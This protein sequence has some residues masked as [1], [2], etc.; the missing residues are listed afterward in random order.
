V[1]IEVGLADAPVRDPRYHRASRVL[2]PLGASEE[3]ALAEARAALV[4]LAKAAHRVVAPLGVGLHVDHQ[5]T[6]AVATELDG[7]VVFYEDVPYALEIYAVARRLAN[8]GHGG[9]ARGGRPREL[10]SL[11]RWWS[12]L[13]FLRDAVP[14]WIR[15]AAVVQLSLN[16]L[17]GTKPRGVTRLVEERVPVSEVR[18]LKR[19]AIAEYETQWPLFHRSIE[20]WDVALAAHAERMGETGATERRWRIVE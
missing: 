12:S 20:A 19:A 10:L 8:L 3:R 16:G 7:D 15:P 13:P 2:A 14:A 11:A 17:R 6:H 4:P 9:P 5:I 18:H 1:R